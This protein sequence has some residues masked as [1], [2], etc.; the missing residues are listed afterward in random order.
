VPVYLQFA[1]YPAIVQ[2]ERS[3][4]LLGRELTSVEK[5][6]R[7][8]LVEGLTAGDIAF[9]DVFE[10]DVRIYLSISI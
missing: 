9:L 10:G 4:A 6:V 7:G 5:S 8:V 2:S 1:D 3:Q